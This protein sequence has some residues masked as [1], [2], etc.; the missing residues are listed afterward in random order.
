MQRNMCCPNRSHASEEKKSLH[1]LSIHIPCQR[2]HKMYLNMC[3]PKP[4]LTR[5]N[6]KCISTC[7]E[8]TPPMAAGEKINHNLCWPNPSHA[9]EY[10][11]CIPTSDV[12]THLMPVRTE[13]LS[14]NVLS[15]QIPCQRGH[16]IYL[17]MCRPNPS[18]A[19]E[20]TKCTSTCD[21]H[22]HHMPAR[23]QNASQLVLTK[24]IS[25]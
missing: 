24:P 25:R 11:K 8:K 6:R 16:K 14:Q 4:S 23:A 22:T 5:E 15:K 1:V 17:N 18:N 7:V 2:G 20:N 10:Q 3:W 9:C 19:S 13:K 12:Q 21:E